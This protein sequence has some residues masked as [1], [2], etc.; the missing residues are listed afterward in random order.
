MLAGLSKCDSLRIPPVFSIARTNAQLKRIGLP[1]VDN[2]DNVSVIDGKTN[3]EGH[4]IATGYMD[5]IET[6]FTAALEAGD[7]DQY[8]E[9]LHGKPG[10]RIDGKETTRDY[11][12]AGGRERAARDLLEERKTRLST[13]VATAIVELADEKRRVP[14]AVRKLFDKM[15]AEMKED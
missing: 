2:L 5:A 11:K 4:L 12:S 13:P 14:P 10:K 3:Y 8:I 6:A 9:D 1:P 7:F 15:S